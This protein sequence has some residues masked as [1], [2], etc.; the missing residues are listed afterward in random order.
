MHLDDRL[1]IATPEGVEIELVLAGL[2]SRF[3]AR[4]L[5]TVIQFA[6]IIALTAASWALSG[7]ELGGWAVAVATTGG[8]LVLFGYDIAFELLD[9]G[10]TPGK[11]AAGI[12]VVGRDGGPIGFV[13]SAIRNLMRIVDFL[14]VAYLVGA[15]SIVATHPGR[16]LGDLAAGTVVMRARI[17][18]RSSQPLP[19]ARLTVPVEQIAAWDVSAVDADEMRLI[20]HFLDRRLALPWPI[21]THFA[22]ELVNRI[23]PKVPGLPAGAHPEYILEGVVVAKQSRA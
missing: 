7:R 13:T 19:A 15:V 17:G 5:D 21:R 10:R 4:L 12:R 6:A 3:V 11:R 2:G 14:P 20:G 1:T 18:A 16:R 22:V 8:F 23:W 9:R